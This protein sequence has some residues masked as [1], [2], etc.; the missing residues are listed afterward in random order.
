MKYFLWLWHH[1]IYAKEC[2]LSSSEHLGSSLVIF[3]GRVTRSFIF[4]KWNWGALQFPNYFEMLCQIKPRQYNTGVE[5]LMKWKKDWYTMVW[6]FVIMLDNN[7]WYSPSLF[8][9]S[10]SAISVNLLPEIK[11]FEHASCISYGSI[12]RCSV[13]LAIIL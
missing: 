3:G 4:K 9:F 2:L 12:W 1:K 6:G 7:K 10:L 5:T 13:H 11:S 8:S